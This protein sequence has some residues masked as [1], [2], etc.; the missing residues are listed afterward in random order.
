MREYILWAIKHPREALVVEGT[1]MI[2]VAGILA[3][4]FT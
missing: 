4:V 3:Y 2:A 1:V